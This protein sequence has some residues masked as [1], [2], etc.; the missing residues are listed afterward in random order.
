LKFF[1]VEFLVNEK[2]GEHINVDVYRNGELSSQYANSAVE[3]LFNFSHA[4]KNIND[5]TTL[6]EPIK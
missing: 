1:D 3:V 6:N 4:S 5:T 2:F